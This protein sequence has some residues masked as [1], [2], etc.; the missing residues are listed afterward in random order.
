MNALGVEEFGHGFGSHEAAARDSLEMSSCR[1]SNLFSQLVKTHI[2]FFINLP[3]GKEKNEI[4][5]S[6][7]R[8]RC[9]A[10]NGGFMASGGTRTMIPY[11][12]IRMG[13]AYPL[14]QIVEINE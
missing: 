6:H 5:T 9:G 11:Q 7:P 3:R 10:E 2:Y 8:T 1:S 14:Q 12:Q 13:S 4:A